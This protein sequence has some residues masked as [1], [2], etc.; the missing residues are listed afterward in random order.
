MAG[1]FMLR[2]TMSDVPD[3][4]ALVTASEAALYADVTVQAIVNWR[5]QGRIEV[6]GTKNGRPAYRLLDVAKAEHATRKR[7]R[8]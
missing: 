4:F 2:R 8:R 1:A 3:P 6:S 5:N 7:A